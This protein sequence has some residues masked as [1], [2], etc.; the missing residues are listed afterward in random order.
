MHCL[1]TL[2]KLTLSLRM[3]EAFLSNTQYDQDIVCL[4]RIVINFITLSLSSFRAIK[5]NRS[6]LHYD[7]SQFTCT[8]WQPNQKYMAIL[9]KSKNPSS[10]FNKVVHFMFLF[11]KCKQESTLQLSIYDVDAIFTTKRLAGLSC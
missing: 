6:Q 9:F 5:D 11:N 3:H 4:C 7:G 1:W 8:H 10:L 2:R